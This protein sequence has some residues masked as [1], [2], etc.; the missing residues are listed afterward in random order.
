MHQKISIS[1]CV[2]SFMSLVVFAQKKNVTTKPYPYSNPVI[3]HMYT[4]DA[5]PKV[6]P[7]GRVWMVT[8]VDHEDGGGYEIGRAHV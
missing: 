4:A 1:I 7:D 8:S 2:L 5:A 6:M 3:H